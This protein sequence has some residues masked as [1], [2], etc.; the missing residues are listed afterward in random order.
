MDAQAQRHVGCLPAAA[1]TASDTTNT[2]SNYT[3]TYGGA[4]NDITRLVVLWLH[5]ICN[6]FICLSI[7]IPLSDARSHIAVCYTVSSTNLSFLLR[8]QSFHAAPI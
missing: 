1:V 3:G 8:L 4:S 7:H 2:A 5:N 6:G